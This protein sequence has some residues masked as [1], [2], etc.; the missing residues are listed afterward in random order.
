MVLTALKEDQK[1]LNLG[2]FS[3]FALTNAD[4]DLATVVDDWLVVQSSTFFFCGWLGR[5]H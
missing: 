2:L 1:L 4:V 5:L 3:F